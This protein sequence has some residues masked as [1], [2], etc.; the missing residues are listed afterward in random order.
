MTLEQLIQIAK[1]GFPKRVKESYDF[2][3]FDIHT[4]GEF[5]RLVYKNYE[6]L[7]TAPNP[8]YVIMTLTLG[9]DEDDESKQTVHFDVGSKAFNMLSA[10]N[11]MKEL[12]LLQ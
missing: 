12:G 1:A 7:I 10:I 4:S 3:D 6:L 8:K 5:H 9:Q 2:S 11:K